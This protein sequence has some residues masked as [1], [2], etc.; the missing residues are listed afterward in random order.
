M[1][2]SR[3]R[4][5]IVELERTSGSGQRAAGSLR[6]EMLIYR[7]DKGVQPML[8]RPLWWTCEW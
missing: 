3:A 5:Y 7:T 6:K 2:Q 8:T 1:Q 4:G